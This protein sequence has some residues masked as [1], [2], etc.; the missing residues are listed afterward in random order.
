MPNPIEYQCP[1]CKAALTLQACGKQYA[2]PNRHSF[3]LAKEGY[4]NLLPVQHKSSLQPGD[5][6]PMLSARRAFLEAGYYA[7]LAEATTRMVAQHF[8]AQPLRLL[9]L[10]CGEGYYSRYLAKWL[11]TN[12]PLEQHGLDIAKFAVAAAAKNQPDGH[13]V[14]ASSL[15][16][17]FPADYF[18]LVLRIF[19]PS[20]TDELRRVLKTSGLLLM[21]TPGPRHLWQLK[22][23]IYADVQEHA[24]TPE[25]DSGFIAIDHQRI[26]YQITPDVEHRNALLQ[27]TPFAW[28]A[29]A[30]IQQTL[31]TLADFTVD[32]DFVL[33]LAKK[34]A[35][36]T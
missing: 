26:E 24:L 34:V 29:S 10:G 17:P 3:D 32:V 31:A 7:Q 16:L 36:K 21:V 27:M 12:H 5:N 23:L 14:V 4:L 2:C 18:D 25:L 13:F 9:D 11:N 1:I 30:E 6:K 35:T 20:N 22:Q 33:T 28:Q 8:P 19:A 15:R